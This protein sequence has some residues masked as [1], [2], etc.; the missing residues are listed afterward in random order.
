MGTAAVSTTTV[1]DADAC[2]VN[3]IDSVPVTVLPLDAVL[4]DTVLV[5]LPCASG[6]AVVADSPVAVPSPPAPEPQMT[7]HERM[8]VFAAELK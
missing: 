2:P 4:M 8:E 5:M 1:V 7:F 6:I 3:G